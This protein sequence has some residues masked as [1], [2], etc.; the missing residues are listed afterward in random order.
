MSFVVNLLVMDSKGID[1]ILG[2][3]WLTKNKV[4]LDCAQRIVTLNGPSD[5]HIQLK[6]EG[7]ESC[8]LAVK[9]VP[10]V[11]LLSILV[12]WEFPYVFSD[13]LPGMPLDRAVEFSIDLVHGVAPISK[14]SYRMLPNELAEL[15]KQLKEL[16]EKGFIHPSSSPWGCSALF[17]S[18]TL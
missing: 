5:T 9:A 7:V 8:L 6:L 18:M 14:R 2:M 16:L 10:T 15:K 17:G 13:E 11:E 4:V 12:V 1:I 3:N